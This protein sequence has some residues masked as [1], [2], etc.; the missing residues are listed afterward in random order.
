MIKKISPSITEL[1]HYIR[2]NAKAT[3][4]EIIIEKVKTGSASFQFLKKMEKRRKQQECVRSIDMRGRVP[5]ECK[6]HVHKNQVFWM[7]DISYEIFRNGLEENNNIFTNE[8]FESIIHG[9]HTKN[10]NVQKKNRV[11]NTPQDNSEVP[12][13]KTSILDNLFLIEGD[14]AELL[15][16]GY[17]QKRKEQ[18]LKH[19]TEILVS[20]SNQSFAAKTRDI[21]S[22]GLKI[23]F[24]KPVKIDVD[25]ELSVTFTGFNNTAD[26]RLFDIKYKVLNIDYKEPEFIIRLALSDLSDDAPK[27]IKSFIDE[28]VKYIKGRKKID[29][30]DTRLTAES[31]LAELYYT[32]STPSIPFFIKSNNAQMELQTVCVN[33]VNKT[34]IKCFRDRHNIFEFTNFSEKSRI[35]KL[36]DVTKGEGQNNPVLAVYTD[37]AGMPEIVFDYDFINIDEWNNFVKNKLESKNIT[38]FKAIV[39]DARKPDERKITAKIGRL[40]TK[41]E[42]LVDDILSFATDIAK[43]GVLIDVTAEISHSLK[44]FTPDSES[45]SKAVNVSKQLTSL[46]GNDVDILQFG[47]TE[48]RREDRYHVSVDTDVLIGETTYT[49]SS[50]DLSIKG[51]CVELE[52]LNA[53]GYKKDDIVGVSFPVLHKRASERINLINIPYTITCVHIENEKPIMHLQREKTKH[54]KAQTDFFKDL[55][56]RNISMI[57]LD[58]KDIETAAKSRII[59]SIV[60]ENTVTLPVFIM[61]G[62]DIGDSK[63]ACIALPEQSSAFSDFFEVEPGRYNFKS[64]THPNR[65]SKLMN[66]S[67]SGPV[68]ELMIYLYKKQIPGIAQYEIFSAIDSDFDSYEN[69]QYFYDQCK[70]HDYRVIKIIASN[71]QKPVKTEITSVIGKL[72]DS[73]PRYAQRLQADFD[74]ITAIGD[75]VDVTNQVSL[76]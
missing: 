75:I 43:A 5:Y 58:T 10:K 36:I 4:H 29:I 47:Y 73:A 57:K 8:I 2:A 20:H 46:K 61:R 32:N 12:E 64:I 74:R 21:S 35:G 48:Q 28:Q 42:D 24:Q 51:L 67:R 56:G 55:I 71:V 54:W 60:I 7:D 52:T 27:F 26:S 76:S 69:R 44:S 68:S 1:R 53:S 59:S 62:K 40:K 38:L 30:E 37:E 17:Y 15:H 14:D 6:S 13:Q 72:Q 63:T 66:S 16:S 19:S 33:K 23:N 31:M 39:K 49:G 3:D 18:R 25:D 41:A 50:R 9:E 22:Q 45:L 65:L 34:V 11:D 70:E